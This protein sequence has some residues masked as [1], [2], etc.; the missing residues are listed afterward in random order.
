M[1][2]LNENRRSPAPSRTIDNIATQGHPLYL[3]FQGHPISKATSTTKAVPPSPPRP[4]HLQQHSHPAST[5]KAAHLY[6]QIRPHHRKGRPTSTA[7]TTPTLSLRLP[8]YLPPRL[9]TCTT[10]AAP[11]LPQRPTTSTAKAVPSLPQRP[12]HLYR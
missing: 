4:P 12:P 2:F 3:H 6:H 10:K 8:P 1:P 11:S 5:T 9:P 7:K